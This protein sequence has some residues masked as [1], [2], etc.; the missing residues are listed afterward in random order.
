[1]TDPTGINDFSSLPASVRDIAETLGLEIVIRL[2]EHFGGVELRIPH[3]LH[4]DHK[5]MVLGLDHAQAL[6]EY[7][8]GDTILVPVS[9]TARTNSKSVQDLED[10]G[11]KR[12][13]IAREL[14]ITQR[15]V[16]RLANSSCEDPNQMSMFDQPTMRADNVRRNLQHKQPILPLNTSGASHAESKPQGPG[17]NRLT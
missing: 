9:L 3:K 7:C 16:R 6:C 11:L 8:P 13:E 12:W 4:P 10:K 17:R 2:V 15:H 5:L 1:M 14:G